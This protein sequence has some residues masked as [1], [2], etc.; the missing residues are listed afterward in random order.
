[1]MRAIA[2][3]AGCE[4][5]TAALGVDRDAEQLDLLRDPATGKLPGNVFRI[6]RSGAGQR[7]PGRPAGSRNRTN[8]QLAKLIVQQHGDP[9]LWLASIY[10][11]PLDQMVEL[12]LI[13]EGHH[14]REAR[15][16]D[17]IEAFGKQL[18]ERAAG[19]LSESA[20]KVLDRAVARIESVANSL[21]A[22]PGD[23]AL[24]AL[25]HQIAAAKE[26]ALYSNSK[27]PIAV[28]HDVRVDGTIIMPSVQQ[29]ISSDPAQGLA[30]RV[31][32]AI[33]GG[34]I[35]A[36]QIAD[37]RV[38]DGDRLVIDGEFVDVDQPGGDDEGEA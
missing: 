20:A 28:E 14:E 19:Q 3:E 37:L 12:L 38:A 27:K 22:K 18:S 32:N 29:A 16:N 35:D 7:G 9:V 23:I 10:A 24:K 25:G 34:L 21:K 11:M 30:A 8:D 6:M 26:V 1:M 33:N 36:S 31:L 5:G 17:L 13:A 15:L 2:D 4:P